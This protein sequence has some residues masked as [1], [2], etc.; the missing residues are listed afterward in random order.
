MKTYKEVDENGALIMIG[1]GSVISPKQ[2]EITEEEY[3]ILL[4]QIKTDAAA[5]ASYVEK[6][7]SGEIALDD[8]PKE[9]KT[10]VEE[11]INNLPD[12]SYGITDDLLDK[13]QQDYRNQV[14]MEVSNA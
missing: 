6:V 10:D 2:I 7:Q 11:V 4:N 13:I 1:K 5:V 12:N 8:V 3:S 9:Y 14:E